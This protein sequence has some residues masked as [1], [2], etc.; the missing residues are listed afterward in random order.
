M[1]I[2]SVSLRL[3]S[4]RLAPGELARLAGLVPS[5]MT[6]KGTPVSSHRP[7]GPVRQ[8]NTVTFDAPL[9]DLDVDSAVEALMPALERLAVVGRE[10]A[11]DL[12]VAASAQDLGFMF[13]VASGTVAALAEAGC[14]LVLDVYPPDDCADGA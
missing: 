7:D 6:A 5:R 8:V 3:Q 14:G 10:F 13:S 9:S 11:V 4:D 1:A 12:V 2:D